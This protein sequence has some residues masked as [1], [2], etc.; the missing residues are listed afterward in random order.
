MRLIFAFWFLP[1]AFCL[2][3]PHAA[4]RLPLEVKRHTIFLPLMTNG[5][6]QRC[7]MGRLSAALAFPVLLTIRDVVI[8]Y[9]RRRGTSLA[10]SFARKAWLRG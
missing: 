3:A 7:S 9:G 6:S 1:F 4:R 5:T 8:C 10:L 2:R